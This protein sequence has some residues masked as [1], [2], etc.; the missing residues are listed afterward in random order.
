MASST[1]MVPPSSLLNVGHAPHKRTKEIGKLEKIMDI[2]RRE[3]VNNY[4]IR[5]VY[6]CDILFNVVRSPYW[7]DLV[8][9]IN[10]SPKGYKIPSFKKVQTILLIKEKSLVEKTIE[11]IRAFY[12]K[13]SVSI[14]F[15]GWTDAR[16]KSL[17]NVI[18]VCPKGSI[19]LNVVDHNRELKDATF[20]ANILIDAIESFSPLNIVQVITDNARVYKVG[21]LLVEARYDHIF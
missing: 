19:F 3:K 17:I 6:A 11:P 20:I 5:Y 14:I 12:R 16:N 2:S 1:S 7:Q 15:D 10:D 8:R 4:V 9:A 13:T 21:R 18:D